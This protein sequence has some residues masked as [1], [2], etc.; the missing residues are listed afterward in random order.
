MF[1]M[2]TMELST[3]MPMAR[4][5]PLSEMM[6]SVMLEKYMHTSAATTL[7]GMAQAMMMVGLRLARKM[8]STTTARIAPTPR[9][10]ST[11]SIIRLMYTP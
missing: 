5:S 9:L 6:F 4:E 3:S 10:C 7:S 8:A 11:E 1:S 2:T